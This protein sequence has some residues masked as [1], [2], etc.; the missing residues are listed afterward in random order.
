MGRD[1]MTDHPPE[2]IASFPHHLARNAVTID[3]DVLLK[4]VVVC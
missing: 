2:I 3:Y 4:G 1:C